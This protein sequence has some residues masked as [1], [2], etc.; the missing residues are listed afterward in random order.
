MRKEKNFK[1]KAFRKLK[2]YLDS[3]SSRELIKK[4][5]E[6]EKNMAPNSN[7]KC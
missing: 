1:E 5:E 4:K 3:W 7:K 2:F 6:R